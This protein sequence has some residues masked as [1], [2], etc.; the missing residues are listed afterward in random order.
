VSVRYAVFALE[1]AA[2]LTDPRL[3]EELRALVARQPASQ[4]YPDKH[5]LYTDVCDVLLRH[6]HTF[7][8]GCWDYFLDEGLAEEKYA[9]WCRGVTMGEGVPTQPSRGEGSAYRSTGDP[10]YLTFTVAMLVTRGSNTDQRLREHC[11]DCQQALWHRQTF[12][13]FVAALPDLNYASVRS[14]VIYLIPGNDRWALTRSDLDGPRFQYLRAIQGLPGA[15]LTAVAAPASCRCG[16]PTASCAA[17]RRRDR[18]GSRC[19]RSGRR[20]RRS[21]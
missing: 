8:R 10:G 12:G 18:A 21:P 9:E 6:F 20:P 4:S 15:L 13:L 5:A 11:D 14:D 17:P 7:E 19:I 2:P 16:C 3:F 1:L